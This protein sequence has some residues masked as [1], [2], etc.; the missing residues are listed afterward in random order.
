MEVET[1]QALAKNARLRV[2]VQRA[3]YW[4]V[5]PDFLANAFELGAFTPIKNGD[6]LAVTAVVTLRIAKKTR[7]RVTLP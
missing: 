2:F 4:S 7:R 1:I 3:P 6:Y 5:S